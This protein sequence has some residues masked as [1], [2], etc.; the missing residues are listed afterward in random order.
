M[1][2]EL[3]LHI[4]LTILTVLTGVSSKSINEKAKVDNYVELIEL[5][6]SYRTTDKIKES[7][8]RDHF[9]EATY[10]IKPHGKDA[11][12]SLSG[13]ATSPSIFPRDSAA[14]TLHSL[15][16]IAQASRLKMKLKDESE[17]GGRL[18]QLFIDENNSQHDSGFNEPVGNENSSIYEGSPSPSTIPHPKQNSRIRKKGN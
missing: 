1:S 7:L 5:F 14:Y 8:S 9:N 4:Y 11:F 15:S 10:V 16:S 18:S 3:K 17:S 6:S 12:I 13:P 2:M